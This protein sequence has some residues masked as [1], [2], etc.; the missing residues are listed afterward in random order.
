M[1]SFGFLASDLD[2]H[3]TGTGWSS[4]QP[5][6]VL[7]AP[8][9]PA[10]LPR[11]WHAALTAVESE[12]AAGAREDWRGRVA[13]TLAAVN[14]AA[15]AGP[16]GNPFVYGQGAGKRSPDDIQPRVYAVDRDRFLY[17][18]RVCGGGAR[19]LGRL[20]RCSRCLKRVLLLSCC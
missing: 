7:R 14:A 11:P 2:V 12:R 9:A 1:E 10:V 3:A 16:A 8:L 20:C 19:A 18:A 15:A 4:G 6:F 17:C 5:V 13:G